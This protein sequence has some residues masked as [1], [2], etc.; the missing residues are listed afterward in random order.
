MNSNLNGENKKDSSPNT[1]FLFSIDPA[2]Y[3]Q[4]NVKI[5]INYNIDYRMRLVTKVPRQGELH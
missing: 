5:Q 3:A 4:W 2:S 1:Q